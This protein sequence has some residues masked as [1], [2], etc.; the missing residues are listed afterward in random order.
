MVRR[1]ASNKFVCWAVN[2]NQAWFYLEVLRILISGDQA[3]AAGVLTY[4]W[5]VLVVMR[6]GC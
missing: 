2:T 1:L 4:C 6:A 3:G 5:L